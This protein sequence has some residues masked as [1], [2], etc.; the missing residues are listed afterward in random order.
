M[1]PS[2]DTMP[3]KAAI[4]V[5]QMAWS[6]KPSGIDHLAVEFCPL[7]GHDNF[8]FFI[9]TSGG[10]KDGAWDCKVCGEVGGLSFLKNKLGVGID[11]VTSV[12][13]T[14]AGQKAPPPL[15]N[16]E[17]LHQQLTNNEKYGDVLDYLLCERGFKMEVIQK[18]K[19]GAEETPDGRKWYVIPYFDHKGQLVY[20]KQRSC[21]PAEKAFRSSAGREAPL[22]N[23]AALVP[24]LEEVLFVE[25]EADCISVLSSGYE[26]CV[27]VPGASVKKAS[28]IERLDQCDPKKVYLLYDSD[29]VGQSNAEEMAK[30]IGLEKCFN[31]KLPEFKTKDGKDGKDINEWFMAGHTLDELKEL[32][33][34]AKQ[35]NPEG[36]YGTMDVLD[37]LEAEI[38]GRDVMQPKYSFKH[39]AVNAK[40][41][42]MEP[43][44]VV[45]VMAQAKIGKTT[46]ALNEFDHINATYGDSTLMFCLEMTQVRMARKWVSYVTQT[47][48][49]PPKSNDDAI[50][51]KTEW[52]EAI[53]K[54]KEIAVNRKGHLLF[55]YAKVES[56]EQV[57][58]IIRQSVRRYGVKFI[59][60]DNIQL[61][62]DLTLKGHSNRTVH[63]SQISKRFKALA[64]ELGIV[65]MRIIQPNRVGNGEI[66]K[67][68]NADGASQIEKD[69]DTMIVFHRKRIM[70]MKENQ[71]EGFMDV[72]GGYEPQMYFNVDLSRY[73]PGGKGYLY[74]DGAKSTVR[75]MGD[76]ELTKP[77]MN[78]V[79]G[80]G[81][82]A[83]ETTLQ[84]A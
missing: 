80:N 82:I 81:A 47:D 34:S 65:I 48:D 50:Q 29:K 7:C 30:R 32:M 3:S 70:D 22:Y 59:V 21:P 23:S 20:V 10:E 39:P 26:R 38:Q 76:N 16:A 64:T 79:G 33:Q 54:A 6:T 73:A 46:Y 42:G 5:K 57:M 68:S 69:C 44:D 25:G 83:Q 41:G 13:E 61:L 19:L 37:Q 40:A 17:Y 77:T 66:V 56:V 24:G 43:G 53:K 55:G 45:D 71:M 74:I 60:F 9:N 78:V 4:F 14:I 51:K 8:K 58:D 84:E 12:Q 28:W 35:F 72:E 49:S 11:G 63:L 2:E 62:A 1:I 67:A 36:V 52:L 75:E 31:V 18:L 27:G 15:P